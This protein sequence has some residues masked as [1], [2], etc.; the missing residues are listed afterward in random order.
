MRDT[1]L[2]ARI[3]GE[4]FLIVMPDISGAEAC[5]TADRLCQLIAAAQIPLR[6]DAPPARVTISIGVTLGMTGTKS[7]RADA[8]TMLDQADR[9]LYK[10]KAEGRNTVTICSRSAA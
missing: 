3:G 7:V 4:E 6:L 5:K 1:D 2:V 8:D 10:A 9:A